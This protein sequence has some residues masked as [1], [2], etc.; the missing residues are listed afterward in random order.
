MFDLMVLYGFCHLKQ[1]GNNENLGSAPTFEDRH[2]S[3]NVLE[4]FFGLN[5]R[6]GF[7][8]IRLVHHNNSS[9]TIQRNPVSFSVK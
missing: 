7:L 1:V 9:Q 4:G 5:L 8:V 3:A 6:S 2:F